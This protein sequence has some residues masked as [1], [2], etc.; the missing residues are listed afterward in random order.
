[1]AEHQNLLAKIFTKPKTAG[2]VARQ[3][4]RLILKPKTLVYSDFSVKIGAFISNIPGFRL[5][6]ARQLANNARKKKNLS[7]FDK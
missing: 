6:I 4:V 3:L 2:D 5:N 1:M 7:I